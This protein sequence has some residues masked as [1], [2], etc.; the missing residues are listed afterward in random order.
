MTT[1]IPAELSS[2]PGIVDNS[3]ATAITIDSSENVGI[4]ITSPQ[5]SFNKTGTLDVNGVIISRGA[6][7]TNQTDAVALEHINNISSLRSYGSNAGEGILTFR[8]GGGGGNADSERMRIDSSGNVLIG[9]TSTGF[10]DQGVIITD[11]QYVGT[12]SGSHC[13]TF[14]RLSSFGTMLR[15]YKDDAAIGELGAYTTNRLY[16]GSGDTGLTF[17]PDY[18]AIYPVDA[19]TPTSRDNAIDLGYLNVRF[20]DVYAT[21]G[22]IQTSD[23][24]E[25]NTITNSDLGL[26][27]VKQLSPKSYKFNGKTR[28]HY[29][30]IAQDVE[31]VLS[32]INKSTT[33]FAGFIKGDVSEEQDG[34]N[35]R[36]GLRYNEFIAPLIKA[37][38]EQQ[39]IIDDLKSRIET[40]EG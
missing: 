9:T 33:D 6:L 24:N 19:S 35:Y 36:Y 11:G 25:K 4:G 28:T 3:D 21:N 39:D 12:M 5:G 17:A 32:D 18:D 38:Q 16:I 30:L 20:D 13:M 23:Q 14:N 26:D 8:T 31:T 10:S 29:G 7:Q 22:T 37:I 1:K 40:L 2:T 34:S 27:F 15:F